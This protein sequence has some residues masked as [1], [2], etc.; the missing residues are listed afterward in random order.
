MSKYDEFSYKLEP[1]P[2]IPLSHCAL[3]LESIF[4]TLDFDKNSPSVRGAPP[5][6]PVPTVAS[7]PIVAGTVVSTGVDPPVST[8][9]DPPVSTGPVVSTGAVSSVGGSGQLSPN[10]SNET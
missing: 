3:D 6:G 7:V 1:Q 5:V 2:G 10:S 8:G 9:V 4:W